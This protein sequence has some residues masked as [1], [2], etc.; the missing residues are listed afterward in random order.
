MT[1]PD[2]DAC[3]PSDSAE[4][5]PVTLQL[6]QLIDDT[7]GTP[8]CPTDWIPLPSQRRWEYE[9]AVELIDASL[10]S[11]I[12]DAGGGGGYMSY[13]LS[14]RHDVLY[15]DRHD[16]YRQPPAPIQKIIG[17]FFTLPEDKPFD[18]ITCV[19]VMEHVPPKDRAR[20]LEKTER[21]LKPGGVAAFTFEW[22]PDE[23]FDIGD[24]LTLT[25]HQVNELCLSSKLKW[26]C[27]E[28]SPTKSS[29]SR[30]WLPIAVQLVREK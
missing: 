24:G 2:L 15:N 30:G 10:H 28:Q 12:L 19:S 6:L 14:H 23:V 26:T 1:L 27:R 5:G 4:L 13:I 22:H 8:E 20:W 9:K 16:C 17:S 29:N 18:A 7:W 11:R 25:E 3:E 21:L